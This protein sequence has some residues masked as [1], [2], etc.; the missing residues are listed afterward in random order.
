MDVVI[1]EGIILKG[2]NGAFCDELVIVPSTIMFSA[3]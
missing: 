1:Y 2:I 3:W